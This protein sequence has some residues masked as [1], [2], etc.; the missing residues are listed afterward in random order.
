MCLHNSMGGL[1]V[2]EL[3]ARC[4][5]DSAAPTLRAM[6]DH[7]VGAVF[8][9]T[10][11]HGTWLA[12]VGWKLRFLGASP[13]SALAHIRPGRHLEALNQQLA[14]RHASGQLQVL[15]FAEGAP[16][17]FGPLLPTVTVVPEASA[18]PGFGGFVVLHGVDHVNVC[19]PR[20]RSDKSYARTMEFLQ[21]CIAKVHGHNFAALEKKGVPASAPVVTTQLLHTAPMGVAVAASRHEDGTR[22]DL[23]SS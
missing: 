21:A 20:A 23:Q 18:N 6:A 9:S 10:P 14:A 22:I 2:K 16:S 7:T 15:S 5:A 4:S 8:Y 12:D 13:A 17:C 19:K 11:H 1:I 3:L